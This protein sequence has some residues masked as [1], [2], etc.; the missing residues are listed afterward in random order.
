MDFLKKARDIDIFEINQDIA[1]DI[2]FL[3]RI[4][5][6]SDTSMFISPPFKKGDYWQPLQGQVGKLLSARVA[7]E[8]S[9]YF[10]ETKIV[11]IHSDSTDFWELSL[12]TNVKKMQRRKYV[13]L[14]I[15]LSVTIKF[16][17]PT[18]KAITTF[19]KDISAGGLQIV[20]E[21]PLPNDSDIK[22][23]LPL[24]NKLTVETKGEILRVTLPETL[25]ER[26]TIAIKFSELSEEKQEQITK[27]IFNKEV[28]RRQKE[29]SLF[30]KSLR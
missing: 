20:V 4:E 2:T 28:E 11:A 5:D 25:R 17:D 1:Q 13:R 27:Y 7:T 24:T 30:D 23:L 19:T 15:M 6:I 3:S 16:I 18:L 29:K 14:T 12:P 8:R 21:N 10:F 26:I 22:I 9:S